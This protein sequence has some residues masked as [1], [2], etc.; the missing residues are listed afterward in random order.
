MWIYWRGYPWGGRARGG[1]PWAD[2]RGGGEAS[3]KSEEKN[4]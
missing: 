1:A 2:R 3:T 4:E